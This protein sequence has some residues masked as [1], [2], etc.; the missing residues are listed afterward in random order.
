MRAAI[1][2]FLL[3]AAFSTA[4]AKS[5]NELLDDCLMSGDDMKSE[6]VSYFQCT[7]YIEGVINT[8]LFA[9][10]LFDASE[11]SAPIRNL[12]VPEEASLRQSADIVVKYL[13]ANPERRHQS[14][15]HLV[16]IALTNAWPC[17]PHVEP[18]IQK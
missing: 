13:Q 8:W 7:S 15:E 12:C 2:F 6:A 18:Q 17:P 11:T 16:I 9:T 14:A 4:S 10:E 3:I 5:G 1:V